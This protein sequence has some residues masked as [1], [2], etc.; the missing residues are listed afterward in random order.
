MQRRRPSARPSPPALSRHQR[1]NWRPRTSRSAAQPQGRSWPPLQATVQERITHDR[2]RGTPPRGDSPQIRRTR[3]PKVAADPEGGALRGGNLNGPGR[4]S[5]RSCQARPNDP[6]YGGSAMPGYSA[7]RR[8]VSTAILLR[9]RTGDRGPSGR[10]GRRTES[11]TVLPCGTNEFIGRS[12][13]RS[14]GRFVKPD[15]VRTE[16][17]AE[18]AGHHRSHAPP[19]GGHRATSG[20]TGPRAGPPG[21]APAPRPAWRAR[22]N[23][24]TGAEPRPRLAWRA[25]PPPGVSAEPRPLDQ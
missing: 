12:V 7:H 15:H 19:P 21:R 6:P 18:S 5:W 22:T 4:W 11:V 2:A 9:P 20:A 8:V 16:R 10:D 13:G 3:G 23:A 17:Q 14:V 25:G 24:A 1:A